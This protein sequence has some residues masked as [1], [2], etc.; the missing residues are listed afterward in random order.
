[1]SSLIYGMPRV[2]FERGAVVRQH[3]LTDMADAII[4]ACGGG[5]KP[6]MAV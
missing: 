4:D 5:A 3:S 2:A 1:V 6:A